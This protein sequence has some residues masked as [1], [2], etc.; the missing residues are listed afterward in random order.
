MAAPFAH[1]VT[2]TGRW[3]PWA[4]PSWTK[5][6]VRTAELAEV[7]DV[8]DTCRSRDIAGEIVGTELT[9][10]RSFIYLFLFL[11]ILFN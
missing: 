5:A 11:K 4:R 2:E 6:G 9:T 7:S 3:A 8:L 10:E 1:R